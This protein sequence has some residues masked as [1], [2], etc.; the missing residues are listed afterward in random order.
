MY[1]VTISPDGINTVKFENIDHVEGH[2]GVWE[3]YGKY[4]FIRINK[5]KI[6]WLERKWIEK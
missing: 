6:V 2:I 5:D 1:I 3:L 4:T